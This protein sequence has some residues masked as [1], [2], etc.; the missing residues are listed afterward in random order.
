MLST[1]SMKLIEGSEI[2]EKNEE[3]EE[4]ACKFA[5][6]PWLPIPFVVL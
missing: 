2:C 4:F 5:L 6:F 3:E 1:L